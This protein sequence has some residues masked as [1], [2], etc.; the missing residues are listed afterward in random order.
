MLPYKRLRHEYNEYRIVINFK[1]LIFTMIYVKVK[2]KKVKVTSFFHV[3]N[4]FEKT[5]N[6][7]FEKSRFMVVTTKIELCIPDLNLS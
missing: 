6:F 7:I 4:T 2:A 1:N 5:G 3:A